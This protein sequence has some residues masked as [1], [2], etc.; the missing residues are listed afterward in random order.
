M[1]L[2]VQFVGEEHVPYNM[3]LPNQY[4]GEKYVQ[5]DITRTICWTRACTVSY[6][7]DNMLE[8]SMHK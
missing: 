7:P 2:F 6:C 8:N 1:I 4:V 3:I 5:D